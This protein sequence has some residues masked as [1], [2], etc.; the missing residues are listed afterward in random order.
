MILRMH[1]LLIA[2]L[3]GTPV[4]AANLSTGSF[5]SGPENILE[6]KARAD[7][8]WDV[9]ITTSNDNA[10]ICEAK[11]RLA[12]TGGLLKFED[13]KEKCQLQIQS[14]A[15]GIDVAYQHET[16]VDL[17]PGALSLEGTYEIPKADCNAKRVAH[18]RGEARTRYDKKDYAGAAQ[19]YAEIDRQCG[20]TMDKG[21]RG[22]LVNDLA[23]S[24]HKAGDDDGCRKALAPVQPYLDTYTTNAGFDGLGMAPPMQKK[25]EKI[26]KVTQANLK[27]CSAKK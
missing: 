3:F 20:E 6:I 12:K 11:G 24:L 7:G 5:G 13:A 1:L 2:Y 16:C 19:I 18:R 14:S 9:D 27:L 21:D 8:D 23:L 22:W 4:F 15:K 17:C 26:V 10:Q 25:Y